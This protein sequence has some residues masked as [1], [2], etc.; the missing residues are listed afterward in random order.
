MAQPENQSAAVPGF[1]EPERETLRDQLSAAWQL[2]TE[3]VQ[4]QLERGWR[5][6]LA[7]TVDERFGSLAAR[8]EAETAR[9]S[10]EAAEA[11]RE[12]ARESAAA[13]LRRYTERLNQTARRL[14][15]AEDAPAWASALLDGL[16]FFAPQVTLFSVLTGKLRY[17]GHRAPAGRQFGD[18]GQLDLASDAAPAFANVLE[19]LDTVI[20]LA[21]PGELTEPLARTMRADPGK[22]ICLLPVT[23]GRSTGNRRV[24]AIV[25]AEPGG[26]PSDTNA[27]ELLTALAG[28]TLDCR[29]NRRA[30]TPV[31]AAP[32]PA[33]VLTG[34]LVNISTSAEAPAGESVEPPPPPPPPLTEL[35]R[36]EQE[37][38]ARAQRFA[39]VRVAEM[40]L[41]QAQAVR[42]GR[43][44]ARLYMALRGEMDRS[45]AQFKHE[46]LH[47]PSMVD[48]FH[49]EVVRTLANDDPALLGP[50]YPGPLA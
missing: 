23:I 40:R 36:E 16:H 11:A 28:A 27:L 19:S 42:Q 1:L 39:R 10:T 24:A 4:Q 49:L 3:E 45:R 37:W 35:P 5:E 46:F 44:Q 13:D 22:R 47:V 32:A 30:P 15:Q 18:F 17:E 20:A 29:L 38:H 50:E 21:T 34:E 25:Y 8:I 2:Q 14:E 6:H 31:K 43:D 9:R 41:Y 7:R 12:A 48:Y 26:T 33:P